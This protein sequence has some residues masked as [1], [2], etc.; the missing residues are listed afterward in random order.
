M[1]WIPHSSPQL[2]SSGPI[3][4]ARAKKMREAP[5][6]LVCTIQERVGD[7]LKIIE[8]LKNENSTIYTLLHVEESNE[9]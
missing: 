1:I 5:Q 9:E 4:R 7:N 6:A 2:R 8:G 3:T